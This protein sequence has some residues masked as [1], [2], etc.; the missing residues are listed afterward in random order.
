MKERKN[1]QMTKVTSKKKVNPYIKLVQKLKKDY[2]SPEKST[3]RPVE[4][5]KKENKSINKNSLKIEKKL[6]LTGKV[7]HNASR[8]VTTIRRSLQKDTTSL[9]TLK[10]NMKIQ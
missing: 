3:T 4:R 5:T 6:Q 8:K 1:N 9:A 2:N 7:D 10:R